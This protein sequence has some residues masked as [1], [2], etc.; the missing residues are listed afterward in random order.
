MET[1]WKTSTFS[2][3]TNIELYKILQ[4]RNE[5]FIV[6]QACPY[7]DCDDK[8]FAAH[9]VCAWQRNQLV[10]YSRLLPPGI[11]FPRE[12]S[13]GRVLTATSA[14]RQDLGKELMTRS[15]REIYALYGRIDIGISAQYY[16]KNFYESFSFIQ[17][18]E[19]YLE[20]DIPHIHMELLR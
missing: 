1:T 14:R 18:G 5:V 12:A 11:A 8:D 16:L 15:I 19:M 9:H 2:N 7:A 4:V 13:I 3:L 6:E 20:D 17:A 10:A